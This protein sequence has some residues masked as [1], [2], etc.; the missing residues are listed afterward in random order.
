MI[1]EKVLQ[2]AILSD[3]SLYAL[4]G[5]K[6]YI[7]WLDTPVELPYIVINE[8]SSPENQFVPVASARLQL[9]VFSKSIVTAKSVIHSLNKLFKGFKGTLSGVPVHYIQLADVQ[10]IFDVNEK[11][12]HYPVDYIVKYTKE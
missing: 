8:I 1:I 3:T 5:E 9:S 4:V 7:N 6:V 12:H 2:D 11:L 10:H